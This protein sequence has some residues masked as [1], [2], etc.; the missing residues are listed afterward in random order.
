MDASPRGEKGM[1]YLV[2]ESRERSADSA[3]LRRKKP[4]SGQ[5][6]GKNNRAAEKGPEGGSTKQRTD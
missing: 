2:T 5:K 4:G 3:Y 6:K 1:N